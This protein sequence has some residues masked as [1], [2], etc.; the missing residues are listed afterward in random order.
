MEKEALMLKWVLLS[1]A[2]AYNSIDLSMCLAMAALPKVAM[3]A[4]IVVKDSFDGATGPYS[5][6]VQYVQTRR[7]HTPERG[8]NVVTGESC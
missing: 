1:I 6:P 7:L 5:H 3:V 4:S 2:K 8:I